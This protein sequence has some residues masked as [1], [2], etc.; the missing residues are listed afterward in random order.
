MSGF[1]RK[2]GRGSGD[3]SF[4]IPTACCFRDSSVVFVVGQDD[5]VEMRPVQASGWQGNQ[6]LIDEGLQ[7]G[8]RIIVDGMHK[9]APGGP[10]KPIQANHQPA[11]E[12][13]ARK[14]DPEKAG[15]T[16]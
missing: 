10:V 11:A 9:V 5:K 12:M 7:S 16:R 15:V 2:P 14:T 6:W 13:S 1:V 3:S 4:R 8:E